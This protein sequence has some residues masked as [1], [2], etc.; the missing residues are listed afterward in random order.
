MPS[1]VVKTLMQKS[2][3]IWALLFENTEIFL[4]YSFSMN[5]KETKPFAEFQR[6][7][8]AVLHQHCEALSCFIT[9]NC[10]FN[11]YF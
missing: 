5:N 7:I 8:I 9:L 3:K 2:S 10:Y 6:S 11:I 4:L 1:S